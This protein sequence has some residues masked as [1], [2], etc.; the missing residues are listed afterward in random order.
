MCDAEIS[1]LHIFFFRKRVVGFNW[2]CPVQRPIMSKANKSSAWGAA[3]VP[4]PEDT[5]PSS[6]EELSS[7]EQEPDPEVSFHQFR[8]P[9]LVPSMFMPYTEGLNMECTVN[10]GFY[11]R[12]LKE[13][14]KCKNI[15]ECE[16][17]ALPED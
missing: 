8:P 14:L 1:S 17:V 15:L 6:Q 16:L 13:H 12:F 3:Q 2:K 5:V 4:L 7:S 9:Q 11:H 10:D